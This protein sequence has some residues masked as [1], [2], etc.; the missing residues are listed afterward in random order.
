M[1]KSIF[2]VKTAA[3]ILTAAFVLSFPSVS[4]ASDNSKKGPA[5]WVDPTIGTA[6]SRW[7][8]FASAARPF[9]M[10]SLSPDTGVNGAWGSGYLYE[11]E[12]IHGMSHIHAWQLSGV[13]VMPVVGEMTGP[14]GSSSYGSSFSHDTEVVRPGYHKVVLDKYDVTAE[15]TSTDRVG[16]HRYTF[17]AGDN[18]YILFDLGAA[19][20][21]S[22]M[23]DTFCKKT[24]EKT[25]EGFVVNAG[26]IRRP[27]DTP[28]F[29]AVEFDRAF[30]EFSGWSGRKVLSGVDEVSG[31]NS[32]VYVRFSTD[33]DTPVLAKVAISYV[34]ADGARLNMGTEL[35]GWDFDA[36]VEESEAVWNE[37]LG[38]IEVEGGDDREMTRFYTDLWHS[39]MGR[40]KVTDVDGQYM[41]MT[42]PLPRVLQVPL[43]G[44]GKPMY[45]HYNSDAFWGA[46]WGISLLWSLAYPDVMSEFVNSMVDMYK[47]GGLIP[48]GPS[49]GNYTFVMTGASSTHF[50]VGA[51]QKGIRDFDV[52]TAYEGLRKNH[53][54][55]G[56][57][58]H[59]GYEHKSEIGG[60]V[61]YYIK[62]GYVP[63]RILP[64]TIFHV[65]GAGQTLEYSYQDWCLA[66][67][68][69]ELGRD[70]D[71]AYFLARSQN[72]RNIYD[73]RTG[74]MR[75]RTLMG[76]WLWPF[77]P[78]SRFGW[79]ESNAL[80]MT[81]SVPHD[82]AGLVELMG[83]RDI[84]NE[85][86]EAAFVQALD[87]NF[88]ASR[89]GT[90]TVLNYSNQPNMQPAHLF[91]YSGAPW[92]SQKWVRTVHEE[93]LS[94]VTPWEGY[95]GDEDQGLLGS[96]GVLMAIGLFDVEGGCGN[97]P[98]WQITSPVFDKVTI[99][100][101]P[102]YYQGETFVIET[103]NNSR[104]N[105]YIRSAK[106]NGDPL[107]RAWFYHHQL[108]KGGKLMLEMGAEP[109]KAWG[110]APEDAPP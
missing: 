12:F 6:D 65:S 66:N 85:R 10:V 93:A 99:H 11:N 77:N 108:A 9:G 19:L 102:E 20:G 4:P 7:F 22:K 26:T 103:V 59:A 67:L 2:H 96:L 8:F 100:L 109:N 74:L 36:V 42:G 54:P 101:D 78:R 21:P 32:G 40:R 17:P 48:R 39:I 13:P 45:D 43:D 47:D 62:R 38:R 50:I 51:Y 25:L 105:M 94:G 5:R 41:D 23:S 27:K 88:V 57:M 83:G 95:H 98:I 16:F 92:L 15:L 107:E 82:V 1:K 34:S 46:R 18:S 106:L 97:P 75:P 104:E 69:E 55:G 37:W 53:M 87:D 61:E 24:G 3:A 28:I 44:H 30:S 110:S 49:G 89:T 71:E 31:K 79:V 58:S 86:L 63:E 76:T 70:E 56:M 80:Q 81:W 14:E 29:F 72:Y 64:P 60:G 68:A 52:E 73:E 91:N 33:K 90:A 35:P 84:F